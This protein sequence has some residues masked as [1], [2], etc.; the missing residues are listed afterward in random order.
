MGIVFFFLVLLILS[1]TL[2]QLGRI[3]L[4]EVNIYLHDFFVFFFS[5]FSSFYFLIRK[6]SLVIPKAF[7]PIFMF[8][9]I[10][11]VSL[12]NALRWLDFSLWFQS[13]LYFFRYLLYLSVFFFVYNFFKNLSVE[14]KRVYFRR[15]IF[16]LAFSGV[17]LALFGFIQLTVFPDFSK[18]DPSLGWDPHKNRLASTF[19]DPNFTGGY[20]VSR[21][22]LPSLLGGGFLGVLSIIL[23]L[24]AIFFTFS[25]SAWGMLLVTLIAKEA[26]ALIKLKKNKMLVNLLLKI[27]IIPIF[28]F[29]IYRF[30][31]AVQTRLSGI[32]DPA[33]SARFR[34]TSWKNA[35]TIARDN[36][37]LGVGFNTY[38]FAQEKY[39]FFESNLP[40]GGHSGS[41][42]DSSLLLV[43][44]TSGVLGLLSFLGFYLLLLFDAWRNRT[45]L[46]SVVFA[47]TLGI[48]AQSVFVNSLF[49]SPILISWWILLG[50]YFAS[51]QK[52]KLRSFAA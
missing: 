22:L 5:F 37:W 10:A 36:F 3:S 20:L 39:G 27:L 18:F 32:T 8:L 28:A 13:S 7:F 4:F 23:V 14:E 30:V 48:L 11:F 24:L 9:F 49:Y 17:I 29:S 40:L 15:T 25:R 21:L 26:Y 2:G 1:L 31:P 43:L 44:A 51:E 12:I 16:W 35:L 47:S 41:G 6:K 45:L 33:D 50:V 38:R 19:F 42:S 46:G 52:K 34:L